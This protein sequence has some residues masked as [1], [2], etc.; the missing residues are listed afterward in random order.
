MERCW[1]Q[2]CLLTSSQQHVIM[3]FHWKFP[4]CIFANPEQ[5]LFSTQICPGYAQPSSHLASAH[6]EQEVHQRN[7]YHILQASVKHILIFLTN[8]T[9]VSNSKRTMSNTVPFWLNHML[10]CNYTSVCPFS[11]VAHKHHVSD[12]HFITQKS[13]AF[14]NNFVYIWNTVKVAYISYH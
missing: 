8:F 1:S 13:T 4:Q 7:V 6:S 10:I 12:Q 11:L 14:L 5:L 3:N 9:G 2:C